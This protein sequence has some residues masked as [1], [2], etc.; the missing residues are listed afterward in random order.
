MITATD[1]VSEV[2]LSRVQIMMEAFKNRE[3]EL[4]SEIVDFLKSIEKDFQNDVNIRYGCIL[5]VNR[6]FHHFVTVPKI[7][8]NL[9]YFRQW[10]K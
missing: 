9:E 7:T 2:A 8:P 6:V 1:Q 10:I 3:L 4:P 5:E